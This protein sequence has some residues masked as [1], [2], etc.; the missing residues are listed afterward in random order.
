MYHEIMNISD[1]IMDFGIQ[2][3]FRSPVSL[4][5][6]SDHV[7]TVFCPSVCRSVVCKLFTFSTLSS[8]EP[9]CQIEINLG[10]KD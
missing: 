6:F 2:R 10:E 1:K 8:P 4:S 9:L 5:V 7:M 3:L